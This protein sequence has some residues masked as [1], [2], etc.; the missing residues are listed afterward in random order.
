MPM[1]RPRKDIADRRTGT[2]R[3]RLSAREEARFLTRAAEARCEP[4]EFARRLLCDPGQ[5]G[6][7]NGNEADHFALTDA[8]LRLGTDLQR[9]VAI[10]ERTGQAP[11]SLAP[12]LKK[13][14]RL[15]DKVMTA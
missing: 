5:N 4:S 7:A 6:H 1:A 9:L 2:L 11:E 10:A 15:L 12:L 14:D 8:L 13:I 3:V